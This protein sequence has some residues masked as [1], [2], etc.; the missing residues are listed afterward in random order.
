[1]TESSLN[2]SNWLK[3]LGNLYEKKTVM[4]KWHWHLYVFVFDIDIYLFINV[5][6]NILSMF[7]NLAF[8][9]FAS[10]QNADY[11][12]ETELTAVFV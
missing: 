12:S 3:T 9:D 8:I 10:Q 4:R 2:I 1:M 5:P 6:S 11:S 7:K